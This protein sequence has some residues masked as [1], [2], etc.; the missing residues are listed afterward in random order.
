MEQRLPKQLGYGVKSAGLWVHRADIEDGHS[1]G[2]N[3]TE[4]ARFKALAQQN[5]EMKRGNEI[6]KR[7]ESYSGAELDRQHK[8]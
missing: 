3:T 4:A 1:P 5:R 6:L 8:K 7:P 2:V